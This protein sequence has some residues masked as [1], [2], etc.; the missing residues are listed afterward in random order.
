MYQVIRRAGKRLC[1]YLLKLEKQKIQPTVVIPKKGDILVDQINKEILIIRDAYTDF[2]TKFIEFIWVSEITLGE[3]KIR[4][5]YL[6]IFY[7]FAS[8]EDKQ[9]VKDKIAEMLKSVT[10]GEK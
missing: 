9:Q 3:P 2:N 5:S 6:T 10:I 4:R 8:E 1:R 7:R